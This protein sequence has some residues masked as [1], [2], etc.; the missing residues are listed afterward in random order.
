MKVL[1]KKDLSDAGRMIELYGPTG[2]GKTTSILQSSP[3]P[4]LYIQ[5][6]PQ[7]LKP[8]LDAANRPDLEINVAVYESWSG[9][10]EFI[11]N[12]TNFEKYS[13]LV[14]D[15]YSHLMNIDLSSEITDESL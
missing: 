1:K 5:T 12:I 9:L 10:M 14:V 2:V 11:T 6:E 8:S 15:S 7:S 3:E 4:V 13:T